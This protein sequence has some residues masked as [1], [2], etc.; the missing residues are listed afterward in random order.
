MVKTLGQRNGPFYPLG[1]CSKTFLKR[2]KPR[3]PLTIRFAKF[4][5]RC[6]TG[7]VIAE[8]WRCSPRP[9]HE[10]VER[11]GPE[12]ASESGYSTKPRCRSLARPSGVGGKA[13]VPRSPSHAFFDPKRPSAECTCACS[14]SLQSTFVHA[15]AARNPLRAHSRPPS[16]RSRRLVN[17]LSVKRCEGG[18]R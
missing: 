9:R 7:V 15:G 12:I 14:A 13:A 3:A 18:R 1:A 4:L 6:R 11:G 16:F 5:H 2:P 10:L 8:L 17:G